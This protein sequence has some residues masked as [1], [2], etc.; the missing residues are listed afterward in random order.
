VSLFWP[1]D[2]PRVYKEIKTLLELGCFVERKTEHQIKI[3]EFNYYWRRGTITKDPSDRM[4]V[5]GFDALLKL[6]GDKGLQIKLE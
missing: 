1:N 5:K 6:L 3:G 2:P 4:K